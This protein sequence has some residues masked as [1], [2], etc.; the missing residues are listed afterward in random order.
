MM[1][2]VGVCLLLIVSDPV[3]VGPALVRP[4]EARFPQA[5][6]SEPVDGIIALGGDIARVIEAVKLAEA[7]PKATLIIS[8]ANEEFAHQFA[9]S[10]PKIRK[11]LVFESRSRSTYENAVLTAKLLVPKL[12]QRWILVTSA[13]H[14]PRAVGTF[15]KAGFNVVP[16]A[17]TCGSERYRL[18]V[19]VGVHEWVG[20]L[21]YWLRGRSEDLFPSP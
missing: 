9:S 2:L 17:V 7:F 19:D 15:R 3:G 18:S 12:D 6:I 14:I 10:Q 21:F 8:G 20:L 16:W 11:R 5:M 13:S 1:P 4:L